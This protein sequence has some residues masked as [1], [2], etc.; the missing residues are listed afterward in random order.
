[1]MSPSTTNKGIKIVMRIR[2]SD[3][4]GFSCLEVIIILAIGFIVFAIVVPNYFAFKNREIALDK[5]PFPNAIEMEKATKYLKKSIK[6]FSK[7]KTSTSEAYSDAIQANDE[8]A[9]VKYK[10]N[11][12]ETEEFI[13]RWKDAAE[14]V[15]ELRGKFNSLN[16]KCN[17][18][19]ESAD[20]K[21]Q[22][23]RNVELKNKLSQASTNKSKKF[24]K[25]SSRANVEIKS[26]ENAILKGNDLVAALEVSGALGA[27]GDEISE[28]D[29]IIN[30]AS[31]KLS[32][33]DSLIAEG[34]HLVEIEF[35]N[36]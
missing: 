24:Y 16:E 29:N 12:A 20:K 4:S 26:L 27:I 3:E 11:S 36:L 35:A 17:V 8:A 13:E 19:F 7:Q 34:M 5:I 1:M 9:K 22:S 28:F 15:A 6:K 14:E 32:E 2:K 23:I 10:Y 30:S 18:F 25:K 21:I 31:S 33:V